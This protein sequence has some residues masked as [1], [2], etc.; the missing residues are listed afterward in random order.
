ME[1]I[2]KTKEKLI[3]VWGRKNPKFEKHFEEELLR[4]YS[5][6]GLGSNSATESKGKTFG[7]GYEL[8]I[9]AFFVGLYSK[10]RRKLEGETKSLGQALHY[11]GNIERRMGRKPYGQIREF[12]F[13]SLLAE[14]DGLELIKLEKGEVEDS[15]VVSMLINTMEEY[16]NYGFHFMN[17]KLSTQPN[18]FFSGTGFLQVILDLVNHTKE[19]VVEKL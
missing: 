9:Y 2:K 8:Y 18:Y 15:E 3:E 12:I 16:A 13:A 14:T 1:D 4:K 5:D 17:E 7:A 6:Y 10:Q 11:W 19:E